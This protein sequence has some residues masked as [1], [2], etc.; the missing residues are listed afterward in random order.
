MNPNLG[1]EFLDEAITDYFLRE[2]TYSRKNL[3]KAKELFK[4]SGDFGQI[5]IVDGYLDKLP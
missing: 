2:Y 1:Q 5:Q 3:Y 4:F